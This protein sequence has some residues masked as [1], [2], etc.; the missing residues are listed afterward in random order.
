MFLERNTSS[1]TSAVTWQTQP[2]S[3][4]ATQISIPHTSLSFLDLTDIDVKTMV[5]TMVSTNNYGFKIR[6]QNEVIYTI[7]DFA[8]SRYS[9]PTKRPKLVVT[10]Q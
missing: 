7:R 3:D 5:A 8:S 10:Y 9:D 2:S 6:L 4:V 1:W